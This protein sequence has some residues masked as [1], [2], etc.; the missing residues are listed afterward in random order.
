MCKARA[1]AADSSAR[2]RGVRPIQVDLLGSAT[3]T[4]VQI[5]PGASLSSLPVAVYVGNTPL[6]PGANSSAAL[7]GGAASWAPC[8]S[9]SSNAAVAG[10]AGVP[11]SV[12]APC[13]GTGR[14][15]TVQLIGKQLSN[16]ASTLSICALLVAGTATPAPTV[17]PTAPNLAFGAPALSSTLLPGYNLAYV[18]MPVQYLTASSVNASSFRALCSGT[19]LTFGS[20]NSAGVDTA[21]FYQVDL[22]APAAVTAVQLWGRSDLPGLYMSPVSVWVTNTSL[23]PATGS[24]AARLPGAPCATVYGAVASQ[25]LLPCAGVGRFVWV[26]MLSTAYSQFGNYFSLCALQARAAAADARRGTVIAHAGAP[27]R[28]SQVYGTANAAL[29]TFAKTQASL[30]AFA[31]AQASTVNA[32]GAQYMLVPTLARRR[33]R[34]GTPP[35]TRRGTGRALACARARSGATR[36]RCRPRGGST[37]AGVTTAAP[38]ATSQRCQPAVTRSRGSRCAPSSDAPRAVLGLSGL[39]RPPAAAQVD[40][41]YLAAVT[42]VT[43]F[44]RSDLAGGSLSPLAVGLSNTSFTPGAST[45]P[46][47]GTI[48][49][50]FTG[51]VGQAAAPSITVPCVGT[52]RYV[53]IQARRRYAS[54]PRRASQRG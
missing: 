42:G 12:T 5:F 45:A 30:S 24:N 48:C 8:Y 33:R 44:A 52:A 20:S 53:Y 9:S 23:A 31:M 47:P 15:V 21:P 49:F 10:S 2:A 14:Y 17:A 37:R 35:R 29:P 18:M 22:L 51:A 32:G 16:S 27:A 46:Q 43:L 39:L 3:V 25:L 1:A 26:Q 13:A 36:P 4:S 40:L 41:Q 34:P 28:R 50:N 38:T 19:A 7:S 11:G 54:V 6:L